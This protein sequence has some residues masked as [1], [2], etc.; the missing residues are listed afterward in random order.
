[1]WG[2]GSPSRRPV[3]CAD[4]AADRTGADDADFHDAASACACRRLSLKR[5][6]TRS[7]NPCATRRTLGAV[8][9]LVADTQRRSARGG[10]RDDGAR[11]AADAGDLALDPVAGI[12]AA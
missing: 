7:S 11:H 4:E 6:G 1:M 8:G 5:S 12:D 2:T 3:S 10:D 9:R